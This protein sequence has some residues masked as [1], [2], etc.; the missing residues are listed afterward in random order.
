MKWSRLMQYYEASYAADQRK[1]DELFEDFLQNPDLY[2]GASSMRDALREITLHSDAA[3]EII[4]IANSALID[5][6]EM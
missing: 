5:A 4:S 1:I 2:F 6:G 3:E